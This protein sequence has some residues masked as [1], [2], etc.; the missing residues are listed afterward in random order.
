MGNYFKKHNI[1]INHTLLMNKTSNVRLLNGSQS[2]SSMVLLSR[3]LL[4]DGATMGGQT[5]GDA[6]IVASLKKLM[7]AIHQYLDQYIGFLKGDL[8]SLP[9]NIDTAIIQTL[10]STFF[11]LKQPSLLSTV[12][13]D[14]RLFTTSL[15][16]SFQNISLQVTNCQLME[17]QLQ[18]ALEK[19]AILEDITKLKEYIK[20]LKSSMQ[21]IPDQM[22]SV[23]LAIIKEPFNTYIKM[24]G[25]PNNMIWEPDKLGFVQDY[26]NIKSL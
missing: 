13:E 20:N 26:L 4:Y 23:P 12:Y 7:D 21:G 10:S 9:P 8:A 22:V 15:V 1:Y 24:F 17:S 14:Y 2:A 18:S 11:N 16:S 5:T 25:F 6:F 19:A 3:Q